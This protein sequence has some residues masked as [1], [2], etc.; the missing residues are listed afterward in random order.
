MN[1]PIHQSELDGN[2]LPTKLTLINLQNPGQAPP[3]P[4]QP[5]QQVWQGERNWGAMWRWRDRTGLTGLGRDRPELMVT[6]PQHRAG[7]VCWACQAGAAPPGHP[8]SHLHSCRCSARWLGPCLDE[9]LGLSVPRSSHL[10]SGFPSSLAPVWVRTPSWSLLPSANPP[11]P[12]LTQ[13]QQLQLAS[14]PPLLFQED[15]VD[16]LVNPGSCLLILRQAPGAAAPGQRP[17]HDLGPQ[18]AQGS[19]ALAPW[20]GHPHPVG[21]REGSRQPSVKG[22]PSSWGS[23]PGTPNFLASG[24][25]AA[26]LGKA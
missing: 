3:P 26:Q 1:E 12:G 8:T 10:A 25:W 16:L 13:K 20:G 4:P 11:G 22:R 23:P 5:I 14:V 18:K 6:F 15:L 19:M 9:E 21:S 24:T 2:I 7:R 17:G